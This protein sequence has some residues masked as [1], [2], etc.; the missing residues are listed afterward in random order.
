MIYDLKNLNKPI[1]PGKSMGGF[2]LREHIVRYIDIIEEFGLISDE[3][4]RRNCRPEYWR[5]GGP[6]CIIYEIENTLQLTFNVCNGKLMRILGMW[7]Y[8]GLLFEKIGIGMSIEEAMKLEP[9]IYYDDDE[10]EYYIEGV[11][12]IVISTTRDKNLKEI[13]DRIGVYIE[14][15]DDFKDNIEKENELFLGK[16]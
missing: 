9:R 5:M 10:E 12:G 1:V 2:N 3:I 7:N 15:L 16:W 11:K 8:K 14:E 6:L 13:I 4:N